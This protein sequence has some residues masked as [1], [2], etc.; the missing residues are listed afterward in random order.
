MNEWIEFHIQDNGFSQYHAH[1]LGYEFIFVISGSIKQRLNG[2]DTIISAGNLCLLRPTDKHSLKKETDDASYI[3]LG[4]PRDKISHLLDWM[5][6][7]VEENMLKNYVSFKLSQAKALEIIRL[8]NS[9]IVSSN[10]RSDQLIM[11]LIMTFFSELVLY[12]N[13]IGFDKNHHPGV[14]QFIQLTESADNLSLPMEQLIEKTGYSY[15]HL[16]RLFLEDMGISVGKY[17]QSKK[18][19]YAKFL[20]SKSD[21]PLWFISESLGFSNYSHF[22]AFFKN[23]T[24]ISP[25]TFRNDSRE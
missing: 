10:D 15:P 11:V 18:I 24:G 2:E 4:M 12:Y 16:N 13:D 1:E 25:L 19:N 14:L 21:K 23:N 22:S 3:A 17:L 7:S 20:L 9:I 8:T 6:K 5:P